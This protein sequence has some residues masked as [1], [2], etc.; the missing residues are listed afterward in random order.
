MYKTIKH[1][2]KRLL[3]STSSLAATRH[4]PPSVSSHA[5][6]ALVP[7]T[8]VPRDPPPVQPPPALLPSCADSLPASAVPASRLLSLIPRSRRLPGLLAPRQPPV[9]AGQAGRGGGGSYQELGGLDLTE[10]EEPLDVL[11]GEADA[12]A[13][14]L[15]LAALLL[16]EDDGDLVGG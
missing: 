13:A 9:S 15:G 11:P 12:H 2:H 3:H 14:D 8:H 1:N 10:V 4:A 5:H 7:R 6:D 16:G